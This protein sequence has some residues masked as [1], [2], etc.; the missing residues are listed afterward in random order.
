MTKMFRHAKSFG[1][2]AM[3]I[4]L[5]GALLLGSVVPAK[6]G[7]EERVVK[8][9]LHLYLTGPIATVGVPGAYGLFDRVKYTNEGGG[10][11]GAKIE[12]LWEDLGAAPYGRAISIHKRLKEAGVILMYTQSSSA[13]IVA[14][15]AKKDEIPYMMISGL[16]EWIVTP[17]PI[18]FF[19]SIEP[20]WSAELASFMKWVKDNWTEPRPP[21]IGLMTYNAAAGLAVLEGAKYADEIGVDFVGH[22]VQPL[23]AIIDTSTEWLRLAAKKPDWIY[24]VHYGSNFAVL[25]SC[26]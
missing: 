11:N 17:P 20:G 26:N 14:P 6:A 2:V 16:V 1:M 25:V 19:G 24:T 7:P 13:E 23:A 22:E 9:G 12:Y 15:L 3:A 8:I 5:S 10:I 18:W 4:L 21:R